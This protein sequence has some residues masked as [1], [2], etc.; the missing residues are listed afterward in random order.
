M[1]PGFFRLSIRL[2]QY[3]ISLNL[4]YIVS[5]AQVVQSPDFRITKG[6]QIIFVEYI[7]SSKFE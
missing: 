7:G 2:F 6:I 1:L 3:Q 5:E 4:K